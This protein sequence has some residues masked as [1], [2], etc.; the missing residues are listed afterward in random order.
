MSS[1]DGNC[2][3]NFPNVKLIIPRL[4]KVY[5]CHLSDTVFFFPDF[6][7]TVQSVHLLWGQILLPLKK[8]GD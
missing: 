4:S 2:F 7:F 8:L 1:K 3:A 6:I 5:R